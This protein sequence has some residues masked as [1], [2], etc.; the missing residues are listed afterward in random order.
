[1]ADDFKKPTGGILLSRNKDYLA[2][3]RG[4]NILLREVTEALMEQEKF[5]RSL[6]NEEEEA[7]LRAGSSA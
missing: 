5:L 3:Y 7:L 6:Q 1:M 2:F 4:K